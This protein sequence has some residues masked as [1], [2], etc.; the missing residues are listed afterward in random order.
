MMGAKDNGD[1]NVAIIPTVLGVVINRRERC[2]DLIE[3]LRNKQL[4]FDEM[5]SDLIDDIIEAKEDLGVMETGL[6]NLILDNYKAT[7]SKKM[8][9]GCGVRIV[10]RPQYDPEEAMS[11]ALDR[12]LALSLDKR[13]FEKI[14]KATPIDFV[15]FTEEIVPLI[16]KKIKGENVK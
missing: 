14:A 1:L 12:K 4:D 9:G 11:W 6:R 15:S 3:R 5:N 13:A 2:F 10:S 16:P 8:Y 7:G